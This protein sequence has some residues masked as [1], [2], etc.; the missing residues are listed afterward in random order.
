MT[1]LRVAGGPGAAGAGVDERHHMPLLLHAGELR[2]RA[3]RAHGHEL[4]TG[5]ACP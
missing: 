5:R 1:E 4:L 2:C 3:V